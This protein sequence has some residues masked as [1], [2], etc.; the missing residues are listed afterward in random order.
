MVSHLRLSDCHFNIGLGRLCA[1]VVFARGPKSSNSG[2][3]NVSRHRLCCCEIMVQLGLQTVP[4]HLSKVD[5]KVDPYCYHMPYFKTPC[6][7]GALVVFGA[8]ILVPQIES[9]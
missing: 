2:F 6:P 4:I 1:D 8:R 9:T 5:H 3:L 7:G